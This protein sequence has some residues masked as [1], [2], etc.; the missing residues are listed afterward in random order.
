MKKTWKS[1]IARATGNNHKLNKKIL[2]L[3]SSWDE[4]EGI[5]NGSVKKKKRK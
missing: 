2:K 3:K 4:V 5:L 1:S